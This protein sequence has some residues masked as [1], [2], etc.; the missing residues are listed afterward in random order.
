M[1]VTTGSQYRLLA[2]DLDGTLLGLQGEVTARTRAAVRRAIDAGFRVC[3]ATGR[4]LTESRAVLDAVGHHDLGVFVGGAMVIDPRTRRTVYRTL[5]D[6]SLAA[7][8]CRV[9]EAHGQTPLALQDLHAADG[10]DYIISDV[11]PLNSQT[12]VW[13]D[14]FGATLTRVPSLGLHVHTNT[15]RVGTVADRPSCVAVMES[16]K[17]KFGPRIVVHS[18]S[19]PN[20]DLDVLEVFDPAVNKWEGILHVARTHNIEPAQVVAIGDELNDLAMIR[21]AGLGVAMGNARAEVKSAAR[22][23]IGKNSEDGLAHF[24]EELVEQAALGRQPVS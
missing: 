6:Q 16:L 20:C 9:I 5:M 11:L 13:M 23:T 1:F 19:V 14:A 24:L 12:I 10:A 7:E 21:Q 4:N 22:R 17:A 2:I 18:I 8:L 15:I 3:L